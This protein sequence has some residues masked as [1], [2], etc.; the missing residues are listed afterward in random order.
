LA[1]IKA[2]PNTSKAKILLNLIGKVLEVGTPNYRVNKSLF[3]YACITDPQLVKQ[4]LQRGINPEMT[5]FYRARN[6]L[7]LAAGKGLMEVVV[8]LVEHGMD[9]NVCDGLTDP[10]WGLRAACESNNLG[11]AR[12]LMNQGSIVSISKLLEK[13]ISNVS[14]PFR[15]LI[16]L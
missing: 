12:Y 9:V 6:P 14:S 3:A 8:D 4:M 5:N 16:I 11:I 13:T 1:I 10:C 7:V 15:S 2:E